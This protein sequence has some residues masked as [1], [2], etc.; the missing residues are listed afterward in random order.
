MKRQAANTK[1]FAH[2]HRE[3]RYGSGHLDACNEAKRIGQ[4]WQ[5]QLTSCKKMTSFDGVLLS[6]KSNLDTERRF[7]PPFVMRRMREPS[8][9]TSFESLLSRTFAADLTIS[10]R[11]EE[12]SC[13]QKRT[14]IHIHIHIHT[15]THT[16]THSHKRKHEK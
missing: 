9:A 11:C 8:L 14:H 6:L 10:L 3:A 2:V 13:R 12:F 5:L 4:E 7:A 15:Y 1:D 16:Y